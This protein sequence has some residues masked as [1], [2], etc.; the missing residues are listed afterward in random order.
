[1]GAMSKIALSAVS[2]SIVGAGLWFTLE[3]EKPAVRTA[4]AAAPQTSESQEALEPIAP[5]TPE[6]EALAPASDPAAVTHEP[7]PAIKA[8]IPAASE[9]ISRVRARFVDSTGRPWD[10][11]TFRVADEN[12]GSMADASQGSTT[13]GADGR[14]ELSFAIPDTYRDP[15]YQLAATR[16]G[17]AARTMR[18]ALVIGGVVD[19]GQVVLERE[20]RVQGNVHDAQGFGL[21][22]VTVG[23]SPVELDERDPGQLRRAGSGQFD[24]LMATRSDARGAF[25]LR[26]VPAGKWRLWGHRDGRGY[27]VSEPFEVRADEEKVGVDFEVPALLAT[28]TIS[29]VVVDPDGKPASGAT[30][31]FNWESDSGS[32]S[33]SSRTRENGDFE[34][35]LNMEV[36]GDLSAADKEHRLAS[37]AVHDVRPGARDIVLQLADVGAQRL[38]RLRVHGPAKEPVGGVRLMVFERQ[39]HGFSGHPLAAREIESGLCE[40]PVPETLFKLTVAAEGYVDGK[41]DGLDPASLPVEL[42]IG[43]EV[44]PLLHGRVSAA[45]KAVPAAV[46]EAIPEVRQGYS[47]TVNG[48]PSV[49]ALDLS[50]R[51]S[52][53]STADGTFTVKLQGK[54]PVY[55]RC[56][57]T[58]FA[59]TIVGPIQ[60]DSTTAPIEIELTVGGAIEGRARA[61]DGTPVVGAIVG[62]TCGDGHPRTMLSGHDGV[63]RFE[64][65]SVG[66]WLVIERDEEVTDHTTTDTTKRERHIEWSCEVLAGRTTYY[67]LTLNR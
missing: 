24:P 50:A 31:T 39:K 54:A 58:G 23:L 4:E 42:D 62:I 60:V 48:F 7:A 67:D 28:D 1:M 13:G 55:L 40:F 33:A 22:D 21:G 12:R 25:E 34:I 6:R 46:V 10:R 57:A 37:A 29:G 16:P 38:A 59:P 18:A 19:L 11:V 61:K 14:A 5:A 43:L 51:V 52:A 30:V 49:M 9:S 15:N 47:V 36:P 8:E 17:C 32:G 44:A 20:A 45:G 53:T 63:F 3:R 41:L 64:G 2:L 65:L 27:G 66:S 56:V 35:L 26:G